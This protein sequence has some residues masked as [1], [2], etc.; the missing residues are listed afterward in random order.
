MQIR[1]DAPIYGI[2]ES[3]LK[4][5]ADKPMTVHDLWERADVREHVKSTEKLSDY[6]GLMW[7]RGLLQRWDVPSTSRARYGYTWKEVSVE[8][9]PI[10]RNLT[11]IT[12]KYEKAN[13][14]ITEHDDKIVLDFD[15]FTLTIQAKR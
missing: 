4:A 1:S 7:R 3:H 9:T 15:K 6:L 5:T 10:P 12:G 14:T 2:L 13:V 8:P 11:R